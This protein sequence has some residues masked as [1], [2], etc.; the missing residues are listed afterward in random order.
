MQW[1]IAPMVKEFNL[2]CRANN[3][4]SG[5]APGWGKT[6]ALQKGRSRLVLGQMLTVT[7]LPEVPKCK[8]TEPVCRTFAQYFEF[9]AD[10]NHGVSNST[11]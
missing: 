2:G 10:I 9:D 8:E 6:L 7:D 3:D 1:V 11:P 5:P 4:C